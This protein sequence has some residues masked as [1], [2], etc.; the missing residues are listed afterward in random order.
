M[1]F[2]FEKDQ[3]VIASEGFLSVTMQSIVQEIGKPTYVYDLDEVV[4]RLKHL[5]GAFTENTT[6]HYAMKANSHPEIL[7]AVAQLGLGVDV[8]SE[9][10]IRLALKAGVDP[11]KVV[12]SGVGKS[13]SEI[14]HAIEVGIRQIN[15]ESVGELRRIGEMA[16]SLKKVCNVAFRMNPDVDPDTHPYIKTGFRD[17]KFGMDESALP[18]LEEVLKANSEYVHLTGLTLHI[19]SQIRE[20][21]S[22]LD[23][24]QKTLPIWDHL[25][26]QGYPLETFDIGGGVGISYTEENPESDYALIAEYGAAVNKLLGDRAIELQVE[27]GRVVVGRSGVLLTEVQYIKQTPYKNFAIVN[28]GM[29]HLMRPSLY[30]AYHRVE[31]IEKYTDRPSMVYDIVGPICESSDVIGHDRSLPR[32]EEEQW[33][34]IRDAGAYGFCMANTYNAHEL[35]EEVVVSE[36]RKL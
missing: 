6:I 7:K 26:E 11:G 31:P 14:R 24:I 20:L 34:A 9:G 17:N 4:R 10:E 36:G 19:G 12:F 29:H 27:P 18:E 3:L 1:A 25:K 32:L 28:S 2:C 22:F 23:A 35:P 13:K 5:S 15:V 8:V 21:E 16:G 33:L 30:S